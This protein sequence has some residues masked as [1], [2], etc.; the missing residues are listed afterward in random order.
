MAGVSLVLRFTLL[1][2]RSSEEE[3]DHLYRRY[4]VVTLVETEGGKQPPSRHDL[5]TVPAIT[6]GLLCRSVLPRG[7]EGP[8]V[9]LS[10]LM[11]LSI[12]SDQGNK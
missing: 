11:S 5:C 10:A 3:T 9:V 7:G 6:R 2:G 4:G 12:A 1:E 8:C